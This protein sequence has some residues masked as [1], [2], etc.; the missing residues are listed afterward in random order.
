MP[1]K[2]YFSRVSPSIEYLFIAHERN[3]ID[4]EIDILKETEEPNHFQ[5]ENGSR[6]Q[7]QMVPENDKC[8]PKTCM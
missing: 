2:L 4:K 1:A 8:F 6:V 5:K 3:K 7:I